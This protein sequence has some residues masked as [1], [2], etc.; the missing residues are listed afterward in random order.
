MARFLVDEDLPRSLAR[1]LRAVGIPAED[2]RDVGLRN[3]PDDDIFTYAVSHALVLLSGDG[4]FGNILRFPL[5]SHPGIVLARF[6]NEVPTAKLNDAILQ[7]VRS[8]TDEEIAGNL[9]II[10]PGRIRLRKQ[11]GA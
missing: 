3:K 9:I 1:H 2:V 4:G 6:P 10:E 11:G 7:A 5:G 8:L